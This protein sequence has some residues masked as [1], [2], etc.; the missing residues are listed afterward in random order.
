[1][2]D[3]EEITE[4]IE[5]AGIGKGMSYAKEESVRYCLQIFNL[6]DDAFDKFEAAFEGNAV[7]RAEKVAKKTKSQKRQKLQLL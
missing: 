1:M 4:V 3:A 7:K 5:L 2:V 6:T